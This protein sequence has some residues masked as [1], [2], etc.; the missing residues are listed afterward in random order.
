MDAYLVFWLP[1]PL[2]AGELTCVAGRPS[3]SAKRSRAG[4][5]AGGENASVPDRNAGWFST[6]PLGTPGLA[7]GKEPLLKVRHCLSLVFSLP[8]FAETVPFLVVLQLQGQ[9]LANGDNRAIADRIHMLQQQLV[10]RHPFHSPPR[11]GS[12]CASS[13][14][15]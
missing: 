13:A 11:S 15:R 14:P 5:E 12:D 9:L 10:R 6:V 8:F 4:D 7:V 3:A 2:S 1:P